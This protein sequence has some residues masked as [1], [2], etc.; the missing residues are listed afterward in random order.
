MSTHP[1]IC[2]PEEFA[3]LQRLYRELDENYRSLQVMHEI[4]Q[5]ER[6]ALKEEIRITYKRCTGRD[7]M[8]LPL[9]EAVWQ[10]ME[11]RNAGAT[12]PVPPAPAP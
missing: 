7:Y 2:T 4:L 9:N 8:H 6:N 5:N 12:P 3:R 10:V 11:K 1:V